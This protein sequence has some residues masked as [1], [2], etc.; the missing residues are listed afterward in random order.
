MSLTH[1]DNIYICSYYDNLLSRLQPISKFMKHP[2]Y[3]NFINLDYEPTSEEQ[4]HID[5]AFNAATEIADHIS[6]KDREDVLNF[7]GKPR[8]LPN[9]HVHTRVLNKYATSLE[10]TILYREVKESII[11]NKIRA[12][13]KGKESYI[14][15]TKCF[16]LQL[17]KDVSYVLEK[18]LFVET[19]VFELLTNIVRSNNSSMLTESEFY[20]LVWQ[21]IKKREAAIDQTKNAGNYI[22]EQDLNDHL[23]TEYGYGYKG[24]WKSKGIIK[25]D[26]RKPIEPNQQPESLVITYKH[27]Q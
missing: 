27:N 13:K 14:K 18:S 7:I 8:L 10:D 16:K 5:S 2:F 25:L 22:S 21:E 3:P 26:N 20:E 12:S 24:N 4:K 23:I 19:A 17:T 1:K 6:T 11:V 9:L 15:I